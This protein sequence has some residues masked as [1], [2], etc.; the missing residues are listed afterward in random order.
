M[1]IQIQTKKLGS[2]KP[3]IVQTPRD[4]SDG[5]TTVRAFLTE[6]VHQE[7]AAY[8]ARQERGEVLQLLTDQE[9]KDQLVSGKVGG[10][11]Q[12]DEASKGINIVK[13]TN[14]ALQAFEDGLFLVM[15]N[16]KQL[17]QLSDS[18]IIQENDC[19]TFIRLTFLSGRLW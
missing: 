17:Q 3:A 14:T 4:I 5:C 7:I 12:S 2:R 1:Q 9:M 13:A 18:L 10:S 19:F 15:H 16:D 8:Q 11:L 6:I